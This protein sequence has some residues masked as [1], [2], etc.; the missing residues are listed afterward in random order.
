MDKWQNTAGL[1]KGR[2]E[3]SITEDTNIVL[4]ITETVSTITGTPIEDLPPLYPKINCE[5]LNEMVASTTTSEAVSTIIEFEYN[6]CQ[7]IYN[8]NYGFII[9]ILS[10]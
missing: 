6:G 7:I 3:R 4:T 10:R 5:A 2:I 1:Q 8:N 9:Q